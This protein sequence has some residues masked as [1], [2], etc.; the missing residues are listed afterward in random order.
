MSDDNAVVLKVRNGGRTYNAHGA[1]VLTLS[2]PAQYRD[3]VTEFYRKVATKVGR[4]FYVKAKHH[5]ELAGLGTF[6]L[7]ALNFN[8]VDGTAKVKLQSVD[9]FVDT[10]H[11]NAL[12]V[13]DDM[14]P[15]F[16]VR[17][18]MTPEGE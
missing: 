3:H 11:V 9:A 7:K 8:G 16:L 12:P 15:E 4:T 2:V 13:Q 18:E 6:T 14:E 5:G 17:F 10:A 1:L